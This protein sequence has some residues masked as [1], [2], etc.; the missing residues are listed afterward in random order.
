VD[1]CVPIDGGH[2]YMTAH[3]VA[4]MWVDNCVNR[5]RAGAKKT[6]KDVTGSF[7]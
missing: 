4:R 3:P 2:G 5:I 6:I 1:E 7:L